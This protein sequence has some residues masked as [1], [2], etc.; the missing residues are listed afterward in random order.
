MCDPTLVPSVLRH[1]E[2]RAYITKNGF[3]TVLLYQVK[4]LSGIVV[5]C[6]PI[7]GDRWIFF[8]FVNAFMPTFSLSGEQKQSLP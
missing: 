5:H 6:Q 2:P 1:E 3:L 7:V 8:N 4:V